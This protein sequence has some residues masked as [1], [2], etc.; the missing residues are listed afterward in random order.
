MNE[1]CFWRNGEQTNGPTTLEELTAAVERGE[2]DA[3]T[4]VSND[5]ETWRPAGTYS[6]LTEALAKAS[7]EKAGKET[8]N[9]TAASGEGKRKKGCG[10]A[11]AVLLVLATLAV[12][13][14]INAI[15]RAERYMK[16]INN[17]KCIALA[18]H[19]FTDANGASPPAYTVDENGEPLHSWRVA[20]LPYIGES[21]LYLRIRHD[22]PWDSEWN[23]QFHDQMPAIYA[24]PSAPL[25]SGLTTYAAVVDD[26]GALRP[27]YH[28]VY[29]GSGVKP[30]EIADG[31][32]N[33]MF[34]VERRALVC[35]MDPTH[36][37]SLESLAETIGSGH[38]AGALAV[39][40]DGSV[41]RIERKIEPETLRSLATA[42]GGEAVDVDAVAKK[43]VGPPSDL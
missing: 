3:A 11:A 22:E 17:M 34:L 27:T 19:N 32:E 1:K 26:E 8:V 12:L 20:L 2:V 43:I 35:W 42:A 28:R 38:A 9:A 6:E 13:P 41:R 14:A 21:G 16:C 18:I 10:C 7:A 30:E 15:P 36:E 39:M 31:A 4:N 24:C 37:T 25:K 29:G 33:T 40:F 5:G 23:S